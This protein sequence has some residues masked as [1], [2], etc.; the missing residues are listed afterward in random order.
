MEILT[1]VINF[2][3]TVYLAI[4][5]SRGHAKKILKLNMV[6][7]VVKL[8]LSALFVYGL[9]G[10][11]VMLGV[12]TLAGQ[13]LLLTYAIFS[14]TRDEGAFRFSV[15]NIRMKKDTTPPILNLAYPVA[16]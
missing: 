9:Q 14:M 4:E 10:D 13:A 5:R 8:S 16:A 2:F 12:A 11:L 1:L 3:N 15:K 6:I 7:V